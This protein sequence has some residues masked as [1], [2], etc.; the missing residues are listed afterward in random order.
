MRTIGRPEPDERL[1]SRGRPAVLA[2]PSGC[3]ARTIGCPGSPKRSSRAD[4]RSS[5]LAQAVV[6]RGRSVVLAHP[7]GRLARDNRLSWL[8]QAVVLRGR[9]GV[10]MATIGRPRERRPIRDGAQPCRPRRAGSAGEG[11]APVTFPGH[12][13]TVASNK[14]GVSTRASARRA[15]SMTTSCAWRSAAHGPTATAASTAHTRSGDSSGARRSPSR[16]M[17]EMG[18]RGAVRGRAFKVTTEPDVTATRPADLVQREFHA[19]R[20]Y[21]LRVIVTGVG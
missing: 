9:T 7:S 16:L 3:L 4:D 1:G 6:Q 15:P 5:C 10:L 11:V 20:L 2:R 19:D 12:A 17:R 8:P 21:C 18:F 13:A 14:R